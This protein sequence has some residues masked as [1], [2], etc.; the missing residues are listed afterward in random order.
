MAAL[1]KPYRVRAADMH[2]RWH[3]MDAD[4]RTLGRLCSEIAVLLQGKH[5][6]VYVPYLNSGDFVVVVNVEKI[7]V[8]GNKL[9]QKIYYRHS[10]YP[11]GLKEETLGR[12]MAKYPDR[13]IRRAVKGMLPKNT[14]GRNML[15]RLKLYA[16]GSHPHEAQII[17][18]AHNQRA[19]AE[20]R[21]RAAAQAAEAPASKPRRRPPVRRRT[22]AGKAAAAET[23]T[24]EAAAEITLAK[25]RSAIRKR[26]AAAK[27]TTPG[28]E[29]EVPAESADAGPVKPKRASRKAPA[30]RASVEPES[31]P[32]G[33]AEETPEEA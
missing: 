2:P 11:G 26:S 19:E 27:S 22:A 3:V 15:S 32:A 6:P 23:E 25:P 21:D 17:E 18:S 12:V 24:P 31:P 9:A 4:G 20:A 30:T 14:V 16:G 33:D 7:K 10:G 8:T 1:V 28:A 5:K 13:A 29:A